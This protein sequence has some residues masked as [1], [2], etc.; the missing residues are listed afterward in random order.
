MYIYIYFFFMYNPQVYP[1]LNLLTP[2]PP[3]IQEIDCASPCQI[4]LIQVPCHMGKKMSKK[5][6]TKSN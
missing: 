6:D 5:L 4:P 1:P 2:P 3:K